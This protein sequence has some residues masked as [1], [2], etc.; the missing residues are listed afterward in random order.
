MTHQ[1]GQMFCTFSSASQESVQ[2]NKCNKPQISSEKDKVTV[3]EVQNSEGDDSPSDRQQSFKRTHT[4]QS[5][6]G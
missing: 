2:R 6:K 1:D 4:Q 3:S 5:Y